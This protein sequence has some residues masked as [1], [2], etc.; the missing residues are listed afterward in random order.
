MLS[1]YT[2]PVTLN[3][4]IR[5]QSAHVVTEFFITDFH[6]TCIDEYRSVI[7]SIPVTARERFIECHINQFYIETF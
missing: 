1:T 3:Y 7:I 4:Y 2:T 5:I 6:L